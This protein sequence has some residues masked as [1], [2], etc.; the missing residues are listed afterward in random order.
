MN[1]NTL[2]KAKKIYWTL[3]T[4]CLVSAISVMIY[5]LTFNWRMYTLLALISFMFGTFSLSRIVEYF[6]L[7]R[8]YKSGDTEFTVPR[9]FQKK[10]RAINPNNS[11][12]KLI[13]FF[14]TVPFIILSLFFAIFDI[15]LFYI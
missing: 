6:S 13:W 5:L 15:M 3:W 10:N 8:V 12:G 4:L 14:S 9:L 11:F 2:E 7:I 1:K